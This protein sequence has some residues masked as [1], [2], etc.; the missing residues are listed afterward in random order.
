M[1]PWS[2]AEAAA[3][4]AACAKVEAA[5]LAVLPVPAAEPRA[6]EGWGSSG[7]A[8]AAALQLPLLAGASSPAS[9]LV[10]LCMETL[11]AEDG[12]RGSA[13]VPAAMARS[14]GLCSCAVPAALGG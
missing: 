7:A 3:D 11:P 12:G 10:A 13:A 8:L 9:R 1:L 4:V 2:A 5:R 6:R 14:A